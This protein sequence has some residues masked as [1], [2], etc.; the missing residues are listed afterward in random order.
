MLSTLFFWRVNIIKELQINQEIKEREVRLIDENGEQLGIVTTS[1]AMVLADERE[2]DLVKISPNAVPPVCKLLNYGK[3][4]FD[5]IKKEKDA[6]KNQKTAEMKEVW[7]SMTI[8]QHDLEVKAKAARKFL[9]TDNKVKVSIRLR[10]RQMAHSKIGI[11]VMND[12]FEIL[13]DCCTIDKK[14]LLEGRS[15]IMILNPLKQAPVKEKETV[16]SA[17]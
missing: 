14:P 5:M 4:R 16:R 11:E 6:R 13:K 2:L 17:E 7:L 12:F 15:I 9:E 1:E 10:G 8:E 3:Y